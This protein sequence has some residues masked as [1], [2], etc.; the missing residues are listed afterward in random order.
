MS[1]AAGVRPG[2]TAV[3]R[4][5]DVARE[6]GVAVLVDGEPVAVFRTH[7]D[8]VHALGNLDPASGA[9]VL[10]R[11]LLGTRGGTWFVASPLYKQPFALH[12][13]VC[14]DDPA[15]RVPVRAVAV[16]DG[17]VHVGPRVGDA[18]GS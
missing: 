10:S 5:E 9:S 12:D 2:W 1:T 4:L 6:S 16:H 18:D 8:A 11:G 15:L 17:V 14:L 3:C 7:D 13:G